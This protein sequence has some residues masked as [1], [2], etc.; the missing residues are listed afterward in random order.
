MAK[1]LNYAPAK[2][3]HQDS[4]LIVSIGGFQGCGVAGSGRKSYLDAQ[5]NAYLKG[6]ITLEY[7]FSDFFS[8]LTQLRLVSRVQGSLD[9]DGA[10]PGALKGDWGG[11]QAANSASLGFSCPGSTLDRP[12]VSRLPLGA[13]QLIMSATWSF[14]GSINSVLPF[15]SSRSCDKQL[16][17][18]IRM[19]R[20]D[21][22]TSSI[23]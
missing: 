10:R 18:A 21:T 12:H 22:A 9:R 1:L 13:M 7:S 14:L 19:R 17:R 15:L 2:P 3:A 4:A 16:S 23:K 6:S 11:G 20:S 5:Q 8:V